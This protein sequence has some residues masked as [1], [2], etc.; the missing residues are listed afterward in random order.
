[1]LNRNEELKQYLVP[2]KH[3]HLVGI[4]GVS[5]RPLGLVLQGMGMIVTGSDMNASVSTDELIAKGIRV[6]IG[7][8][9]E[10]I[11][12]ADCIIRTAA[13]HNDNPE[14]AAARSCGIPL[15]ERAQAW[16]VIM[17]AYK[18]AICISGTHGKTTAT[19]MMTHILMEAG[20]D[21]T[22]MIGGYLPLLQAGHRV[23]EGDTIVLE[24]CEYCD[25]FLNFAPTLAVILNVEADHLDYFKDLQDVEKS[26][27][28]FAELSTN[29]VIANG[30][31]PHVVETLEGLDYTTFG[32]CIQNTVHPENISLDWRHM[33]VICNDAFYCHLDLKVIGKHNALNALAAVAAAWKLGIPGEAVAEG[34]KTFGGADRR[35]QYKGSINGADVYDDYAHHPDELRATIEAVRTMKYDR[36]VIA[37]QPHTYTRTHALFDDFVKELSKADVLVLAEIYAAR[38]RNT[39]GISSRDLQTQIPGSVYCRTLPQVTDYLRSIAG[40]GDVILTV[41][42]GDIFRAG[43]ALLK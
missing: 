37:F 1:M 33:D 4:G 24:S 3:V 32:L 2:G 18:N 16:G 28:K 31:D 30:D 5:M 12:G 6:S 38:E 14:I 15:F 25:S 26:F 39:V 20:W 34:L 27:R 43:E 17:Q 10:N 19:S 9:A 11:Q 13:A 21:P 41:G 35:M 23:G 29:G 22:V 8:K 42:A 7:H 40:P 36:V